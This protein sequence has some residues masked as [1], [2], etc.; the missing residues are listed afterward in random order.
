VLRSFQTA[1][2]GSNRSA[3]AERRLPILLIEQNLDLICA[4]AGRCLI[5]EKGTVTGEM[6]PEEL[7]RP[8]V[9]RRILAI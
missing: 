8:D 2:T 5:I 6:S 3:Y 1:A 9:A 4:C 7:M